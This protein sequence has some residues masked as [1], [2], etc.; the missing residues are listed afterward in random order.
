MSD[1]TVR[2]FID[3]ESVDAPIGVPLR[4]ILAARAPGLAGALDAGTAYVTNGVGRRIDPATEPSS[5]DIFRVVRSARR[6][7]SRPD[8]TA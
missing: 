6:P 5:G 1:R 2:I 7:P 4:E 8:D 3:E